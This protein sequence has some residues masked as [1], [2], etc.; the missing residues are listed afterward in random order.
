MNVLCD[1]KQI[2]LSDTTTHYM[3]F[4]SHIFVKMVYS[5]VKIFTGLIIL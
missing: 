5:E 2:I 3:Y 4:F 1:F